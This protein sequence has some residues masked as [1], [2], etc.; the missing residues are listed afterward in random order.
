MNGQVIGVRTL[1]VTLVIKCLKTDLHSGAICYCSSESL[2]PPALPWRYSIARWYVAVRGLTCTSTLIPHSYSPSSFSCSLV[3]F[4][5]AL[6]PGYVIMWGLRALPLLA[7]GALAIW[8]LPVSQTAGEEVLWVNDNVEFTYNGV[9]S[10][11][12]YNRDIA[13]QELIVHRAYA[14]TR[15]SLMPLS[16][17]LTLCSI[18]TFIRVYSSDH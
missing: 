10:V 4:P 11:S 18:R 9:S 8:P 16:V 2:T 7:T 15:S 3:V 14:V 17:Q 12:F 1:H 13:C 6:R 5:P